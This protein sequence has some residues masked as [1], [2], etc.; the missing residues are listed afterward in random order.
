MKTA[1]K[2]GMSGYAVGKAAGVS[3]RLVQRWFAGSHDIGAAK[4]ERIAEALG[5]TLK[6]SKGGR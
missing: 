5:L 6:P 4:L 1:E 3:I 2:Q